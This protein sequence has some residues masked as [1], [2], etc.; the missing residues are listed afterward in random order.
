MAATGGAGGGGAAVDEDRYGDAWPEFHWQVELTRR[1]TI[2][3]GQIQFDSRH[4]R[5]KFL[6]LNPS[7]WNRYFIHKEIL[8]DDK[9]IQAGYLI[10]NYGQAYRTIISINS[11]TP[12]GWDRW[13]SD[14]TSL[15]IH[16]DNEH[17]QKLTHAQIDYVK[18]HARSYIGLGLSKAGIEDIKRIFCEDSSANKSKKDAEIAE[19]QAQLHQRDA[20]IARL[21]ELLLESA[22]RGIR[23]RSE[24]N[25][26]RRERNE[27]QAA[28]AAAAPASASNKRG[29]NDPSAP[30]ARRRRNTRRNR[31]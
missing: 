30:N 4:A 26:V 21:R 22:Q 16:P 7:T 27:L 11:P 3:I 2:G 18:R 20:E 10:D 25:T 9:N 13:Y 14:R 19:L 15:S 17:F 5:E 24:R 6:S 8:N 23:D 31:N 12:E 29:N 28:A 1:G